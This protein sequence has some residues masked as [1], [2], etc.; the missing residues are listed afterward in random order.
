MGVVG[1]IRVCWVNLGA[2]K[3]SS[4]SFSF[5]WSIRA[6]P[7]SRLFYSSAPCESLG[8]FVVIGFIRAAPVAGPVHFG[9]SRSFER[10][11]GV[12]GFI[13]ALIWCHLGS[14][15]SFQCVL[16]VAIRSGASWEVGFV[17]APTLVVRFIWV[18]SSAVVGFIWAR[19][20]CR[21]VHSCALWVSFGFAGLI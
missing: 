2:P 19:P 8:S 7:W 18:C 13:R 10:I 4:V 11:L 14:L 9:T 16:G 1:F 15:G 12:V 3:G 17:T 21:R 6:R 20:L 5:V